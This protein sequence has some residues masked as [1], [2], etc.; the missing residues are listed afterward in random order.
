MNNPKH[1]SL[2]ASG[3][4]AA[5]MFSAVLLYPGMKLSLLFLPL[6]VAGVYYALGYLGYI[7]PDAGDSLGI[8]NDAAPSSNRRATKHHLTAQLEAKKI[9]WKA[10]AE[11]ISATGCPLTASGLYDPKHTPQLYFDDVTDTNQ[12]SSAYCQAH[13]RP[14]TE[15]ETDLGANTVARYNFI[16]PNLCD[17]MHGNGFSGACS[18]LAKDAGE[19]KLGDD[20]LAANVPK[21]LAS[22]A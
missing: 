14:F 6:P 16:T 3:A 8:A 20:W 7:W 12:A 13:V 15:F 1:G 21:I 17:D 19:I 18:L 5:V 2:G 11:G 22:Q 4:V 9:P 10:Y